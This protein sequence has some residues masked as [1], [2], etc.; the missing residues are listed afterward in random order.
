M[1]SHLGLVM[2]L[3]RDMQRTKAFY[4]GLLGYEVVKEFSSPDEDFLFL[5]SKAGGPNLALQDAGKETYGI[6]LEH[7]G[8]ALG[9]AVEDADAVYQDWQSK[10]VGELSPVMDIGAGHMF[11]TRDPEGNTIQVYSLYPQVRE[12]QEKMGLV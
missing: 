11:A 1:A 9:F 10:S 5:H 2:I 3:T 4:T 12:V 6:S 8:I 7:G